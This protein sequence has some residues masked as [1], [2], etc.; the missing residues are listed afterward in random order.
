MTDDHARYRQGA[1]Y[2]RRIDTLIGLCKGILADGEVNQSEVEFLHGWLIANE[3]GGADNSL[4]DD[5]FATVEAVLVDGVL[6]P[7][8]AAE[9]RWLLEAIT[10]AP[11][12]LG[13]ILRSA[14]F[15]VDDPAPEVTYPGRS[16]MF[17]GTCAYGSRAQ[18]GQ[19][20][21]ER[22]GEVA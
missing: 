7:D 5:L 14:D 4:F 10:G 13:E 2:E 19:A 8:E 16:F 6:D 9:I 17:T 22:G 18:C 12:E 1:V 11:S 15:P 21:V 20:V 3:A